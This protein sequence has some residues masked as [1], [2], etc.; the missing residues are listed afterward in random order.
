MDKNECLTQTVTMNHHATISNQQ[1]KCMVNVV[2]RKKLRKEKL[3]SKCVYISDL[4]TRKCLDDIPKKHT[5]DTFRTTTVDL[6]TV[7]VQ[8]WTSAQRN[9]R[10]RRLLRRINHATVV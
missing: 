5:R 2:Q 9:V 10:R 1:C 6:T 8:T 7:R 3:S 4:S